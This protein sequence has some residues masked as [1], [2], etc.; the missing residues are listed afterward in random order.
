MN[1]NVYEP[2][3]KKLYHIVENTCPVDPIVSSNVQVLSKGEK[4]SAEGK[5]TI[6]DTLTR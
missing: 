4:F 6:P 1:G 3:L 2:G 5:D